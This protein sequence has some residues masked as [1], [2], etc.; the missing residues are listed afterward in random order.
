MK[1]EEIPLFARIIAIAD[2]YH[3][4]TSNRPYRNALPAG[5]AVQE[6]TRNRGTQFDAPL[7]DAFIHGLMQRNIIS[8][9]DL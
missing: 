1:G 7:V 3:A 6:L 8:A 5:K 9:A 2:A 4:M